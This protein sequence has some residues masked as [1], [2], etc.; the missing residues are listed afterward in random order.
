MKHSFWTFV[1][2]LQLLVSAQ[3][4]AQCGFDTGGAVWVQI[5]QMPSL[6]RPP[7]EIPL[8]MTT[9]SPHSTLRL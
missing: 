6:H 5:T 8:S 9:S 1:V 7:I 3:L 2:V 4:G